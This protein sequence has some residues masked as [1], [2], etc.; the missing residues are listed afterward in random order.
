MSVYSE[1]ERREGRIGLLLLSGLKFDSITAQTC[2]QVT[3]NQIGVSVR[4]LLE[5]IMLSQY[6]S[7]NQLISDNSSG[8]LQASHMPGGPANGGVMPQPTGPLMQNH[9]MEWMHQSTG[10]PAQQPAQPGYGQAVPPGMGVPQ[11]WSMSTPPVRG[12]AARRDQ[13][14]RGERSGTDRRDASRD[15]R[16]DGLEDRVRAMEVQFGQW[17]S[18]F[19]GWADVARA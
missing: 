15:R 8:V 14:R 11:S 10:Q 18:Y 5:I 19:Q 9:R 13:S 16:G 12:D 6:G 4:D 17:T 2:S 7:G 1:H 3:T